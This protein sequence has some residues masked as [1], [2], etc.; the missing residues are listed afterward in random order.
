L[1]RSCPPGSA[2][3]ARRWM[4]SPGAAQ[5]SGAL[6]PAA[7]QPAPPARL[8]C[9]LCVGGGGGGG[10]RGAAAAARAEL[11]P[12]PRARPGARLLA[13]RSHASGSGRSGCHLR[14]EL[15]THNA[16]CLPAVASSRRGVQA[17]SVLAARRALHPAGSREV[18]AGR[19]VAGTQPK[20]RAREPGPGARA[21]AEARARGRRRAGG[22]A[23][24]VRAVPHRRRP[25]RD[26][27]GAAAARAGR[28]APRRLPGRMTRDGGARATVCRAQRM[29]LPLRLLLR[30]GRGWLAGEHACGAVGRQPA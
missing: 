26:G 8:G 9:A 30:P 20:G 22:P 5:R 2:P 14:A 3:S 27:G 11:E 12:A 18:V 13:G 21:G 4:P 16:G 19:G 28:A 17:A 6:W 1:R 7:G 29:R 10:R 25:G 24:P 15:L 23:I